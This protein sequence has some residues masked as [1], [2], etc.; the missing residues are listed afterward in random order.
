MTA[1]GQ[2]RGLT[3]WEIHGLPSGEGAVEPLVRIALGQGD[4]QS[5]A[6]RTGEIPLTSTNPIQAVPHVI[7]L[8]R[9]QAGTV[10]GLASTLNR[11]TLS[12]HQIE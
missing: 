1:V 6:H 7:V 3:R 2:R 9:Q 12:N 11:H 4:K 10:E 8:G 5:P